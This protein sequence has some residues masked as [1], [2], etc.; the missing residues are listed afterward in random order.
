M[1][2]KNTSPTSVVERRNV[3]RGLAAG[4]AGALAAPVGLSEASPPSAGDAGS[5]PSRTQTQGRT[6]SAPPS[7]VAEHDRATLVSLCD[8]VVPGSVDAGVPDLVDRAAAVE[9][10]DYQDAFLGAIRAFEGE[11][12]ATHTARWI[13]LDEDAHVAILDQASTGARPELQ[14]HLVHL[15]DMIAT[16]YFATE[17][18]MRK[19]GW[20]PRST[21]RELPACEHPDDDHR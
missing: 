11:A 6:D 17:P 1:T 5:S 18:G 20:T 2:K 21:W 8:L 4:L 10:L 13:D 9:T 7:I 14:R 19:L 3:L 16:A 12:R 15:R